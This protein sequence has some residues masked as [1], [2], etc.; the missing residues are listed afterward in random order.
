MKGPQIGLETFMIDETWSKLAT[1]AITVMVNGVI[2]AAVGGLFNLEAKHQAMRTAVGEYGQPC[3]DR[4]NH[5]PVN[6]LI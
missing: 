2:V 6:S 4:I 5:T 3:S 1:F